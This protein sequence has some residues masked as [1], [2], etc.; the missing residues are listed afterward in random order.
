MTIRRL[1]SQHPTIG[2][3]VFVAPNAEVIADVTLA[4]DVGIWF[5]AVLRGDIE[6]ISIGAR[7]N[8]QD[9]AVL[10]T[11][12]GAPCTIGEDVTIGHGAII[13]G[14]TVE[15]GA[16]IGMGAILLNGAKVGA[17]AIVA[18]GALVPE[19]KEVPAGWLA[20]GVPAKAVRELT[21][22]E[23]ERSAKNTA[24]YVTEK[25]LYLEEEL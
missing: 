12:L 24:H 14:A 11:D 13:H 22:A 3:R 18:A 2:E 21:A 19:G 7:S 20:V 6:N 4:D 16:L 8:V 15:K 25:D 9:N 1:G 10:H 23:I 5:G 17:G